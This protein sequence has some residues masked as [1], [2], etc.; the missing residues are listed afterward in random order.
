M[1]NQLKKII[2]L[3]FNPK[4]P[5]NF[6]NKLFFFLAYFGIELSVEANSTSF[7]NHGAEV[8]SGLARALHRMRSCLLSLPSIFLHTHEAKDF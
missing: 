5:T 7:D 3:G 1:A 2:V 6:I 4:A 8:I